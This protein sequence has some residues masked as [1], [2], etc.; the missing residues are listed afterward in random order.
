[1]TTITAGGLS[2]NKTLHNDCESLPKESFRIHSQP[3]TEEVRCSH[4]C[5][6]QKKANI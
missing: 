5:D 1:M 4:T 3:L 6:V 2:V